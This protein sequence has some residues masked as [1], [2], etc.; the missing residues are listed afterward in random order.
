MADIERLGG[1]TNST[2]HFETD[3]TLHVEEKQ[4]AE[5]ILDYTAACRND[6]FDADVLDGMM[7][8]EY[9]IP[10]VLYIAWCREAGVPFFSQEADF[11]VEKKMQDPYF[12]KLLAA[13]KRVDPHIIM[14]GLR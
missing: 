7:R 13:P 1:V 14:T 10:A 6:R 3:G 4:D 11:I 12:A 5:P 9:E 2:L 8:H